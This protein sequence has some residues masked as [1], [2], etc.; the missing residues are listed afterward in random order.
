MDS[1]EEEDE[2]ES[3]EASACHDVTDEVSVFVSFQCSY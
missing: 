2:T 1:S 3:T